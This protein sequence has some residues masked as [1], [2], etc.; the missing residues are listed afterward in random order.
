MNVLVAT[1][2]RGQSQ[3]VEGK[4]SYLDAAVYR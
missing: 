2:I 4:E 3:L 1:A